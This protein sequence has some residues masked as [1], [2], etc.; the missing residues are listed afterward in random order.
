[1]IFKVSDRS[2]RQSSKKGLSLHG[3]HEHGLKDEAR[4]VTVH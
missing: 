4:K 3:R 1:L 2:N